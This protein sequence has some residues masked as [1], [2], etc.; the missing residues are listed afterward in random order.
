MP[1]VEVRQA[2]ASADSMAV[3]LIE[4]FDNAI[5]GVICLDRSGRIVEANARARAILRHGDGLSDRSGY[6]RAWSSADNV[7]LGNIL[8]RVLPGTNGSAVGGSITVGRSAGMPR[9]AL[10]IAPIPI[11]RPGSS[12][13]A[14]WQRWR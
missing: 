12:S 14:A 4:L 3:W 9:F 5:V 6:L 8:T 13:A 11:R 1:F 2:L 10:H 7:R